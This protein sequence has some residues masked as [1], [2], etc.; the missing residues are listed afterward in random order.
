MRRLMAIWGVAAALAAASPALADDGVQIGTTYRGVVQ[1]KTYGSPQL[2]LPPGD[3]KLVALGD[4]VTNTNN[5]RVVKGH[6]IQTAG[7]GGKEM[8]GRVSF[9]VTDSPV[10]GGWIMPPICSRTDFIANFSKPAGAE[11]YD[12]AWVTAYSLIRPNRSG[13]ELNQF[14]DYVDQNKIKKPATVVG[15][16]YAIS[17]GR[18]YLTLD[19]AFNPDLQKVPSASTTLWHRD[20]YKE[21][22]KRVAYVERLNGWAQAWRSTVAE[23]YKNRLPASFAGADAFPPTAPAPVAAPAKAL[24]KPLAQVAELG[25]SYRDVLP[26]NILGAPQVP[27]P[28]GDWKLIVLDEF[29]TEANKIRLVRGYLVQTKGKVMTGQIYFL[30]PDGGSARGWKSNTCARKEPLADLTINSGSPQGYDCSTLTSYVGSRPKSATPQLA[31]FH[32]YLEQNGIEA[33]P[34]MLNVSY[35]ISDNKTYL[36]AEYRFN[37]AVEGV[38][39]DSIAAW[40]PD[41]FSEDSKRAAYVEKMKGWAQSWHPKVAAGYKGTLPKTAALN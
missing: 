38:R 23:A 26:L 15:V 14:Y 13:D 40:R 27:L 4:S 6:L 19:Y 37:P 25:K 24:G 9:A 35:D 8:R 30:A 34:T 1:L 20:R 36:L 18:S 12:C 21:D 29:E 10:R 3:W 39:A 16:S 11:G 31:Q 17:D 22:P 41:R 32:N 28:P 33:P 2:P 5:I 7:Q